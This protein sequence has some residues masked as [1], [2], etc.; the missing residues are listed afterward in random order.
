MERFWRQSSSGRVQVYE[1]ANSSGTLASS[2]QESE[3]EIERWKQRETDP[4]HTF[5]N[6]L[7]PKKKMV[8]TL[9]IFII[10]KATVAASRR[11]C[12]LKRVKGDVT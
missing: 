1:L 11:L 3:N 4:L 6:W 12:C 10:V 2:S 7:Q 8:F 5:Q 9:I